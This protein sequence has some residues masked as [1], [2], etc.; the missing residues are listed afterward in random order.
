[1]FSSNQVLN[2]LAQGAQFQFVIVGLI[3]GIF[4]QSP[5]FLTNVMTN[6]TVYPGRRVSVFYSL[7]R[8]SLVYS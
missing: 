5:I 3:P 7:S 4:P 1:M 6:F 2:M 8:Y